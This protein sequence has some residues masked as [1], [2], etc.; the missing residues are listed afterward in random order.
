MSKRYYLDKMGVPPTYSSVKNEVTSSDV[1]MLIE[2]NSIPFTYES[3]EKEWEELD[4]E[5]ANL[6]VLKR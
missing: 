4:W 2:N 5:E 3:L 1:D 6:M